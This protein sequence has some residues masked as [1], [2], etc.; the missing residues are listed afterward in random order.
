MAV[1]IVPV[2]SPREL[3]QFIRLPWKIYRGN[4]CW[5]PTL[6][7]EQTKMFSKKHFPFF[8][9][10]EAEFF[11]AKREGEVLGRIAAIKN[12]NHLKVYNDGVGFFGFFETVDD[13][14]V[15]R[16]LLDQAGEWLK[17]RGLKAIRGPENYSQNETAGLLVDAFDKPPVIE[18]TY[19]PPYYKEH[20][21]SAGFQERMKLFAY[22]IEGATEIPERLARVV[23]NIRQNADFTVRQVNMKRIE[24]EVDK[25]RSVYNSAW[26]ENWGAVPFTDNEIKELKNKLISIVVP[27][28]CLIAE[29]NGEAV[30][31]SI[32]VPDF[33]EVLIK[34][35]SGR[36]LPFGIFKLLWYQRKI[37]GVRTIIMGVKKEHRH[38]GIDIVFYYE[39]FKNGLR[40]GFHKGEMSWILENNKPMRQALD[41]IYGTRIYK[42]Y[43][44]Y[45]KEL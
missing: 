1:E 39:T 15:A 16:A 7:M 31:T 4:P 27:D 8:E 29:I 14:E 43:C 26:S 40:H 21:E 33:N 45:E 44:L 17:A 10:S 36:L 34:L 3:H 11:L 30:G 28:L 5:V 23:E 18:M 37:S 6:L 41:K 42:T 35:K 24:E 38:K 19:N 2:S 32:T 25:I 12:N 13:R 22:A 20:I 9:H